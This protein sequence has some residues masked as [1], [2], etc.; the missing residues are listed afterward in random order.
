MN[1]KKKKLNTKKIQAVVFIV[2]TMLSFNLG[3]ANATTFSLAWRHEQADLFGIFYNATPD[4]LHA[5]Y[6]SLVTLN[7]DWEVIGDLAESWEVNADKTVFTFH[8]Y[9]NVTWHDGVPVTAHDVKFTIDGVIYKPPVGQGGA[10]YYYYMSEDI[11]VI[12][13]PE[14]DDYTL[15]IR[16]KKPNSV[17]LTT[18]AAGFCWVNW[19]IPKHI[20]ELT[21]DWSTNEYNSK[22]IGA[23]P[24][25]FVEWVKGS[26]VILEAYDDYFRGRPE[27]DQLI[28]K[29]TG[30]AVVEK[31]MLLSGDIDYMDWYSLSPVFAD[32]PEFEESP[33]IDMTK[34]SSQDSFA[35]QFN[36]RNEPWS[37]LKVRQ[38]ILYGLDRDDINQKFSFGF[39]TVS[40]TIYNI[41]VADGYWANTDAM[42]P[43]YDKEKAEQ[44]L[45]EAGY[46][47][48]ADGVRFSTTLTSIL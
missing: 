4:L 20:Y 1:T 18:M 7:W 19:I 14:D 33:I 27:I 34:S 32:L 24:Y 5:I 6:P 46:P 43:E 41:G 29:L 31:E 44:L 11:D 42:L 26:H 21:P 39:H 10:Y 3:L 40:S 2:F 9:E 15:I 37:N 45:D 13:V 38:A 23:G 17:F 28:F 48:G 25:K 35:L 8:L 16:L 22:P 47:R 30:S 36:L 12:E